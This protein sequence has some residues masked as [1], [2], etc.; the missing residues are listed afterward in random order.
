VGL[1]CT[2]FPIIKN[3]DLTIKCLD[4]LN[5]LE[6]PKKYQY[7]LNFKKIKGIRTRFPDAIIELDICDF[8]LKIIRTTELFVEF[9][10]ES[11]NYIRHKH[12][13]S[14][15]KCHLI[16]CWKHEELSQWKNWKNLYYNNAKPLP[17]IL[18]VENLLK[19]GKINLINL[20]RHL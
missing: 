8:Q 17:F 14:Q 4:Y 19:T 15:E 5:F 20:N 11:F 13:D 10:F 2:I 12:Y 6:I 7:K 16:V 18:S 1:F 3:N 9:E